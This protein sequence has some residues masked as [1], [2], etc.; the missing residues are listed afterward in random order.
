MNNNN[1]HEYN[2][3]EEKEINNNQQQNDIKIEENINI[4]INENKIKKSLN[5]NQMD[6]QKPKMTEEEYQK[7]MVK[8]NLMKKKS[9]YKPMTLL[10]GRQKKLSSQNN[11]SYYSV[12]VTNP[13]VENINNTNIQ[14]NNYT[15]YLTSIETIAEETYQKDGDNIMMENP[16]Y[17]MKQLNYKYKANMLNKIM[18]IY[19]RKINELEDIYNFTDEYLSYIIK[20]FEKL[21]QPF[22]NSLSNIFVTNIMPNL[23]Y[24]KEI[25]I[26]FNEFSEKI[27]GIQNK[28]LEDKINKINNDK[29]NQL[30]YMDCNLNDSVKKINNIFAD[31][32]D[33]ISKKIQNLI[34][35]NPLFIKI[36]SIESKYVEIF[37]KMMVYINKLTH[38]KNKFNNKYN[39]EISPY[40][41]GIKQRLNDPTLF[42]F[43]T[44]GKDF[45]FIEQDMLLYVN[46]IYSKISQ[47]LIN[48]ELLFK[49]SLTTFYDYLELLNDL[50][51]LYY[52]E[53]KNVLK[54]SSLLP[55][56]SILNFD[57]LLKEKNIRQKIENK[58]SFHNIIE[59]HKNEKLF[60]NI[61]HF[62]LNY[63]DLLLQYNFVKNVDIEEV[64]NF[65]LITYNSSSSFIQFLMKLIP[66]KFSFKFKDIIELKMNIKRNSGLIKGW[67]NS[68]LVVT[69][70]GHIFIFDQDSEQG[71][72]A[73]NDLNKKNDIKMSRKEIINSIIEE[74][75]IKN[76]NKKEDKNENDD[77]YEAIKNNKLIIN[78]WRSNFGMVKLISKDN[79]KLLQLYEDY[80][81]FRQYR[82]TII[83]VMTENNL[84]ILISTILNNKII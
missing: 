13:N 50:I 47:F 8:R 45:I 17:S 19:I 5:Q 63:R 31:N 22:I 15:T 36:D 61:N 24:F 9:K 2:K 81:G 16:S 74:N 10:F 39:K 83:D 60:N 46:K 25:M 48:M 64:I 29:M 43:L 1:L 27:K 44:S 18:I 65:N 59:N 14:I 73:K 34:I 7:M 32:F 37:N 69:Y 49:D 23:K 54:I 30:T 56:K 70:Q 42:Q 79:K 51:K 82:P 11:Q 40:F 84:N 53:N 41:S 38:R 76:E 4:P 20:I 26:I 12:S 33:N 75:N 71:V 52:N 72:I 66:Q 35:N 80:M 68:L 77:L 78:Y 28:S 58:F 55:N 6:I 21:C 62:L 57:N 3:K 67:R